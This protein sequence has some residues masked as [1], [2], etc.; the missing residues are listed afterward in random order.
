MNNL[1]VK[2]FLIVVFALSLTLSSCNAHLLYK[3][4]L[5]NPERGLFGKTRVNKKE[6]KVKEP[7][8]VTKAKKKQAAKDKKDKKDAARADVLSRKRTIE[9]QTPEVQARMKQNKIDSDNRDKI[10]RKN[11]KKSSKMGKEKYSK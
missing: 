5:R 10:K 1:S 9:I 7:R 4:G 11:K 8:K 6:A 2:K 3:I